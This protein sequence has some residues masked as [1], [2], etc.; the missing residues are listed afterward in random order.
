[1]KLSE[2]KEALDSMNK[3][4]FILENGE[5]VP[6][7]FHVTEVGKLS[8]YFIDCGG[9]VRESSVINFQLY[10]AND[11]EHR[12]EPKKLKGIVRKSERVL[13]LDDLDIEVEYQS[14]T[15]GKYNLLLENGRFTLTTTKT[16][17]LAKDNC[18]IQ[19]PEP[20]IESQTCCGGSNCC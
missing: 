10:V 12:L 6:P 1:M 18:G 11:V 16:D 20:A 19:D 17:C 15:I 4:E 8:R 2:F 5:K 13:G 9:M 7:H 3:V 14:S